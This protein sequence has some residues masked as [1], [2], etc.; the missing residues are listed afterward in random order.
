MARPPTAGEC[1]TYGTL[2]RLAS[3]AG[4][5]VTRDAGGD[6][7]TPW[8]AVAQVWARLTPLSGAE[9]W[10]T[11]QV[12]SAV[13]HSLWVRHSSE[14]AALTSRWRFVLPDGR[15][16]HFESAVRRDER[17]AAWWEIMAR[18]SP[19]QPTEP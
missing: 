5:A 9:Q 17:N 19:D 3:D 7:V 18:E 2:E 13:T 4:E 11:R 8:R 6:S 16:L 15:V 12:Q 10:T 14:V 1:R